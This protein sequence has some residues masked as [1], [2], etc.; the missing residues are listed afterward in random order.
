M[1]TLTAVYPAA[2]ISSRFGGKIKAL[3]RVG[4]NN[5]TLLEISMKNAKEAGF[6]NFV[7]IASDKTIGPLKEEIKDSFKGIPVNYCIQPKPAYRQKPFGTTHALLSAKDLVNE[8][9][10]YLSSDEIYSV[11][12]LKLV[13]DYL[14][15]NKNSYCIPGYRLKNVLPEQGTVNR[16]MIIEKNNYLEKIEEQFN[17]SVKDIPGKYTGNELISVSICGLQPAFFSYLEK[18]FNKFLETHKEDP[19]TECLL[20]DSLTNFTKETGIKIEIIPTEDE[21]IS[22]TN[23]EDEAKVREKLRE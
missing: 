10:I 5:E 17:I 6:N 8:P 16:G 1:E 2:G 9:F 4:P 14:K 20:V 12:T 15:T 22:L 23:P 11:N 7:I 19:V 18:D 3:A 21:L 13:A